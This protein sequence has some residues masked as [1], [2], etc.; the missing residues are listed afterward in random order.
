MKYN[1]G[2]IARVILILFCLGAQAQVQF[3][4]NGVGRALVTNN[5]LSGPTTDGDTTSL[6]KGISGYTL[7]DLQPNLL[8]N[9]NLKANVIL[10]VRNPFGSFFGANTA[11]TFRQMQVSGR[12]GKVVDYELGDIYLGKDLTAYTM[13]NPED[14]YTD[15][16]SDIHKIRR[17]IVEYENFIDGNQW[18]LQGAKGKS[19]FDF[20]RGIKNL[21]ISAFF[22]RINPTNDKDIADQILIGS[23]IS[24]IQSDMLRIGGTYVGLLDVPVETALVEYKNNVF[25]GDLGFK[26]DKDAFALMADVESG[27]SN[28]SNTQVT[29]DSTVTYSDYFYDGKITG[30]VK[31]AKVKVFVGMRNVGAQYSSPSAQTI[32][33]NVNRFPELFSAVENNTRFRTANLFDR[34]TD[35]Y[36]YNR[37]INPVLGLFMPEYGNVTPYGPA[38]P[39]RT[40]L[41]FG[42]STDTS[43]KV[44]TADVKV[45]LLNEIVGEGT[46]DKRKFMSIKGGAIFRI[47]TLA[48]LDRKVNLNVGFRSENTTRAGD[49]PV[50]LKSTLLDAGATI[51]IV[52]RLDLLV[53]YKSL[54]ASGNE[55][56]MI[57]S[58]FNTADDYFA[59]STD[60][61]ESTLSTGLGIRFGE[62]SY[63]TANYNMVNFSE[64]VSQKF[65]YK[66]N[67]MFVNYSLIF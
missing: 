65:D 23:R 6:Q 1:V 62:R 43:L 49:A 50:D 25:T 53:G 11:F 32:R 34:M 58:V 42:L 47:G 26:L 39:N 57:R 60:L 18:R 8:I 31:P 9:N 2:M 40:G 59:Y 41:S 56:L 64:S 4:F 51:E 38:T 14:L 22:T 46:P 61:K 12:I 28:F 44:V 21:G 29:L 52:K 67:Q 10:R 19:S 15:Y 48:K 33:L 20:N 66:I 7:F 55:Y 27:I 63:F 24:V 16:E 17:N 3:N 35:E 5:K 45:D 36:L 30:L 54:T 37:G 13:F